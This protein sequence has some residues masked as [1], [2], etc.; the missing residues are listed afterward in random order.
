MPFTPAFID[1]GKQVAERY[2]IVQRRNKEQSDLLRYSKKTLTTLVKQDHHRRANKNNL[3]IKSLHHNLDW[4]FNALKQLISDRLL[5]RVK[6]PEQ[7]MREAYTLFGV[8]K[9]GGVKKGKFRRALHNMGLDLTPSEINDLFDKFDVDNSGFLDFEE[10]VHQCMPKDYTKKTWIQKRGD[11]IYKKRI[12]HTY[13]RPDAPNFPVS[14]KNFR[15]TPNE[16][17][18]M[19]RQKLI[20]RCKRPE[21]QFQTAFL[22]FGK[23]KFGITSTILQDVCRKL[24]M[25][26]TTKECKLLMNKWDFDHSGKLDFVEFCN[27]IMGPDYTRKTWNHLRSEKNAR[28]SLAKRLLVDPSVIKEYE[29]Q[30][31][32]FKQNQQIKKK[33]NKA[34]QEKQQKDK[35]DAILRKHKRLAKRREKQKREYGTPQRAKSASRIRGSFESRNSYLPN[36]H[37]VSS[38]LRKLMNGLNDTFNNSSSG[39]L[40]HPETAT[41]FNNVGNK[42]REN[43]SSIS[44]RPSTAGLH[45]RNLNPD[46]PSQRRLYGALQHSQQHSKRIRPRTAHGLSSLLKSSRRSNKNARNLVS[47]DFGW[48]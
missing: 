23:P 4:N 28:E 15:W 17:E 35:R 21:E 42:T 10:L 27:S 13:V 7:T 30:T 29:Q 20:A 46:S 18:K 12:S 5:A 22:L 14:T 39:S 48:K 38:K 36:N 43:S 44:C 9:D 6:R 41:T 40:D 16:I 1:T 24:G 26:L 34:D 47:H 37:T 11:A 32:T 8:S 2:D 25:S 3:M 45:R 31:K 19:L 33:K